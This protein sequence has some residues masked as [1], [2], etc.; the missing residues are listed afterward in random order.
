MSA[1]DGTRIDVDVN[2][3]SEPHGAEPSPIVEALFPPGVIAAAWR[4]P[5]DAAALSAEE[6]HACEGVSPKRLGD[7]AAGRICARRVLRGFGYNNFSLL[8]GPDRRPLWPEHIVG[9]IS[10]TEGFCAAVAARGDAFASLGFDAENIGRVDEQLWPDL[11][12]KNERQELEMRKGFERSMASTILF[13]A[14]EAYYKCE[15]GVE[16]RWIGF[17]DVSIAFVPSDDRSGAFEVRPADA[18]RLAEPLRAG[19]YAV[20]QKFAFAGI[21]ILNRLSESKPIFP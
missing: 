6:L 5:G 7:F 21:S 19:R 18:P 10:H 1:E 12:T 8:V 17:T 14:K 13:C 15:F 4:G 2:G 20:S 16:P 3:F 11:F 9:S